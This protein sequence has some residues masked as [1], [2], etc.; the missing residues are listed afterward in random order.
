MTGIQ[1]GHS[2]YHRQVQ[3]VD[4]SP[5]NV[6]QKLTEVCLDGGKVRLRSQE[7]GSWVARYQVRQNQKKYWYYK[8]QA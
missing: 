1:V 4:T 8:L 2:T 6:R 5:P 3:K 7:K